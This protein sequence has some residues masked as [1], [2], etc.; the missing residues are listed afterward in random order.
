[1]PDL[2][3][4]R[5][6]LDQNVARR[7]AIRSENKGAVLPEALRSEFEQL[8]G[9]SEA[10]VSLIEVEKQKKSDAL[11]DEQR[12]YLDEPTHHVQHPINADDAGRRSL[13]QAG[14]SVKAGT[15]YAPTTLK[16]RDGSPRMQ[17]MYN[18][19]V[20]FGAIPTDDV[21]AAH[22]VKQTRAVSQPEYRAAWVKWIRNSGDKSYLT[23][24]EFAALS[25]GND[26]AGGF[27]VPADLQAD[28]MARRA[29]ESVMRS[30]ATVRTTSRDRWATPAIKPNATDT[31]SRNI[32]SDGFVGAWVGE[33]PTQA[34]I[35]PAFEMFEIAIKKA[36]AKTTL[37]N[38]LIADSTGNLLATLSA[39]GARNLALVEDKGFIQGAGTPLEPLG[40]LSHPLALTAVASD[41][42]AVDVEGSVANTISNSISN[43]GSAPLIK[44]LVYKL[45]SQYIANASWL[46][47]RSTQ[48]EIA[49]LVDANGRPFW[50]SY[51]DSGFTRPLMS[52]E[53]FPVYNSEFVGADGSVSAGPSTIP[54]IFGDL[55]A[56]QIIDRAQI[57]V[58]VLQE[59]YADTDQTGLVLWSRVSGGLW[60]YDAIRTGVILS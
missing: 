17:A 52:I 30:L 48:G 4:L 28:L 45:A 41:G 43:T 6:E 55:S 5:E 58:R 21:D 10:L 56:Y 31:A 8:A 33:T 14:W 23:Q 29:Q 19:D 16:E 46:M 59:R 40:I 32:Y 3:L 39:S 35:D 13:L 9:R 44:G 37:S 7:Q 50:N 12:A 36:R 49:G 25:E 15:W 53:G 24:R 47:R 2:T 26:G 34:D 20:L 60:N 54:L 51:L 42:M 11:L 18:E 27:T 38:D 1:M 57:S 22:Y